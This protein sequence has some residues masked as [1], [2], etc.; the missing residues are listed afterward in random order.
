M[1][2]PRSPGENLAAIPRVIEK[3]EIVAL[4][5]NLSQR[6]L[7]DRYSPSKLFRI[8]VG[9]AGTKL[10]T[11]GE[12]LSL[13]NFMRQRTD[14]ATTQD[15]EHGL[16][17]GQ[18]LW[19]E[20]PPR[21]AEILPG[22]NATVEDAPATRRTFLRTHLRRLRPRLTS[23]ATEQAGAHAV[24]R[25]PGTSP[26]SGV[27]PVSCADSAPHGPGLTFLCHPRQ[28]LEHAPPLHLTRGPSP[29]FV[30][31]PLPLSRTTFVQRAA[32]ASRSP[33]EPVTPAARSRNHGLPLGSRT[34]PIPPRQPR[35]CP[36]SRAVTPRRPT[37]PR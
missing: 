8:S 14:R 9:R 31:A 21:V 2:I 11:A 12:I 24:G 36:D 10:L 18:I 5:D 6:L 28:D 1:V 4:G 13:K 29:G 3:H 22:G 25:R 23:A 15:L 27:F 16:P 30:P 26:C 35:L 32:S 34:Q 17:A 7:D 19:R 33:D 37:V 20:A